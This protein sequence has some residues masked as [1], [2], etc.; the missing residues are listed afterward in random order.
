MN[1]C[2]G[3]ITLDAQ[4]NTAT[5][6]EWSNGFSTPSITVS[7]AKT[8]RVTVSSSCGTAIDSVVVNNNSRN[9]RSHNKDK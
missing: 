2:N 7:S 3:A 6:Y 9:S 5:A 8:Y 4:N 1:L